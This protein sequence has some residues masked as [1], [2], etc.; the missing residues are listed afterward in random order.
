MEFTCCLTGR[1]EV[2]DQCATVCD[3]AVSVLQVFLQAVDPL[4]DV[5]VCQET[6]KGWTY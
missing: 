6:P 4:A 5:A 3:Q 1:T 2:S